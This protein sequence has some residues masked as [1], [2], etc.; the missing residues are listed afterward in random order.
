MNTRLLL[1]TGNEKAL[2]QHS[3]GFC[4]ISGL[5]NYHSMADNADVYSVSPLH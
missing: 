2:T 3:G 1:A 4:M 5:T